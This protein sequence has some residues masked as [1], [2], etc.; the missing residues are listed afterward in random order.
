MGHLLTMLCL[1][2]LSVLYVLLVSMYASHMYAINPAAGEQHFITIVI[3][4]EP[5]TEEAGHQ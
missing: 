5:L 2:V 4:L 3:L 1:G